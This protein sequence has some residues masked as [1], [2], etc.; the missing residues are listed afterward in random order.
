MNF[1]SVAKFER[2]KVLPIKNLDT[3][4]MFAA[5][6]LIYDLLTRYAIKKDCPQ[7]KI[8][9]TTIIIPQTKIVNTF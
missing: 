8:R 2:E 7:R 3:N 4:L 1:A 9:D 6:G 5:R